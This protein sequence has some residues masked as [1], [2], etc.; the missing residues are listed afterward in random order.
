VNL[1]QTLLLALKQLATSLSTLAHVLLPVTV[2]DVKAVPR[3]VADVQASLA[4]VDPA[5]K[6]GVKV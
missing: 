2:V 6:V 1:Y 3:L 5:T 4:G